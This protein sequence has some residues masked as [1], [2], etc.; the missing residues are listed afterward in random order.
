MRVFFDCREPEWNL[1][2]GGGV[3]SCEGSDQNA[4]VVFVA[5]A[6]CRVGAGE[7]IFAL[8]LT[9]NRFVENPNRCP[10]TQPGFC[11]CREKFFVLLNC[12]GLVSW[13]YILP[14]A[15]AFTSAVL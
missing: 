13:L 11:A 12:C 6:G 14:A 9:E 15:R 10:A 4:I 8:G 3:D 2:A 1:P 5:A 7:K